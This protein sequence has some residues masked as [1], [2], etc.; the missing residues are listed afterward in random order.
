[1]ET[2][3]RNLGVVRLTLERNSVEGGV[4]MF[5]RHRLLWDTLDVLRLAGLGELSVEALR[6][7]L[8]SPSDSIILLSVSMDMTNSDTGR[9]MFLTRANHT[10]GEPSRFKF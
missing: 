6:N 1:M 10:L 7:T 3:G 2:A 5:L 4:R 9:T 8:F